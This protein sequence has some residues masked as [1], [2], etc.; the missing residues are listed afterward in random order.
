TK[1]RVAQR[2][3]RRRDVDRNDDIGERIGVLSRDAEIVD[4]D[5]DGARAGHAQHIECGVGRLQRIYDEWITFGPNVGAVELD[6]GEIDHLHRRTTAD[7]GSTQ[8]VWQRAAN[9]L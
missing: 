1:R 6:R 4:H 3:L 5:V 9:V 7:D 8:A 2:D